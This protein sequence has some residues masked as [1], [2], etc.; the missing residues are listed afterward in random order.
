MVPTFL[1]VKGYSARI[2][3][4]M[5]VG[6]NF[7][8]NFVPQF[9]NVDQNYVRAAGESE[10]FLTICMHIPT[11]FFFMN[12][13]FFCT[14]FDLKTVAL[15]ENYRAFVFN[16]NCIINE[17][18]LLVNCALSLALIVLRRQTFYCHEFSYLDERYLESARLIMGCK[19]L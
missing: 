3:E 18:R 16:Q 7:Y 15:I 2:V 5:D 13:T 10:F 1:L 9:F 8:N 6:Y 4:V 12:G 17:Q 11:F 19:Y 14:N